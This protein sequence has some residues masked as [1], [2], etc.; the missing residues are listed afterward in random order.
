MFLGHQ[1]AQS[2]QLCGHLVELEPLVDLLIGVNRCLAEVTHHVLMSRPLAYDKD[3]SQAHDLVPIV[4]LQSLAYALDEVQFTLALLGT[5][6]QHWSRFTT[7]QEQV[8]QQRTTRLRVGNLLQHTFLVGTTHC[9]RV[10]AIREFI[11]LTHGQ[12]VDTFAVGIA[13]GVGT[14][15]STDGEYLAGT[16][17]L[18]CDLLDV[19]Q[20]VT[21]HQWQQKRGSAYLQQCWFAAQT[22]LNEAVLGCF[23]VRA[24]AHTDAGCGEVLAQRTLYNYEREENG[25][26]IELLA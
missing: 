19:V 4:I 15:T 1:C 7:T 11:L 24:G 20:L 26:V 22:R 25:R 8:E 3:A 5:D 14:S 21:L 23:E 16:L 9:G 10:A 17:N 12:V 6:A 2:I 18:A 13:Y